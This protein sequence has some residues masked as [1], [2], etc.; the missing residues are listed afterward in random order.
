VASGRDEAGAVAVRRRYRSGLREQQ[1]EQ[2][3]RA[4]VEA[5]QRLFVEK[6][7]TATGMREVA[8]A[9][10]VALETVYSHFS[11]K[12]G[13]LRAV[14]DAAVVGD[15]AEVPLAQRPE[16]LAIGQG[17]RPARIRAAA[18]LLTAVQL[19]TA[20]MAKLLREAAPADGEIAEML[21]S[22]R[23]RQRRDVA[24][25]LELIVGRPPTATERDGAWAIASPEVFLLLVEGS[26]WAPE[27]YEA[28][29]AATLEGVIPRS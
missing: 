14:T 6:G 19:R 10:G 25:A 29:V 13:L 20:A 8:A 7:W 22:T 11:S 2:T 23:D 15:D 16:F 17:R 1:A 18:Q 24:R 3:Q 28:W 5:A 4:V 21:H 27:E 9:A 26:G 12:R